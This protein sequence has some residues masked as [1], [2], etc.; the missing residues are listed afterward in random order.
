MCNLI[1]ISSPFC[2][3]FLARIDGQPYT[4]VPELLIELGDAWGVGL[5]NERMVDIANGGTS[6]YTGE[7]IDREDLGESSITILLAWVMVTH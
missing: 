3:G 6:F 4:F 2:Y 7:A 5:I 1:H